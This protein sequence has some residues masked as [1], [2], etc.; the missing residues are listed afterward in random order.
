MLSEGKAVTT[1]KP[2]LSFLTAGITFVL[3]IH[4]SEYALKSIAAKSLESDFKIITIVKY[5]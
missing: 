2:L 4:K 5:V 3:Y 1:L